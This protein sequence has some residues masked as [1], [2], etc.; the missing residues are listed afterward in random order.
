VFLG[1][2]DQ[3]GRQAGNGRCQCAIERQLALYL[4]VTHV[5]IR[6]GLQR[7]TFAGIE[8][9]V[10]R[11]LAATAQE[12]ETAAAN[13]RAVRLD[14]GQGCAGGYGGIE[15]IA[16]GVEHLLGGG[17]GGGVGGGNGGLLWRCLGQQA[18]AEQQGR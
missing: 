13:T 11:R 12:E 15:G 8:E 14:H 7:R 1:Q 3:R 6:P 18:G 16:T 9:V 17:C 5:E 2:F 10:G 4:A